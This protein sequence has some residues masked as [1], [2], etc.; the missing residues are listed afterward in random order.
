MHLLFQR[1]TYTVR[2]LHPLPLIMMMTIMNNSRCNGIWAH[3]VCNAGVSCQHF[4]IYELFLDKDKCECKTIWRGS[5]QQC[6]LTDS[7]NNNGSRGVGVSVLK[8]PLKYTLTI[9]GCVVL[10]F[11]LLSISKKILIYNGKHYVLESLVTFLWILFTKL[12]TGKIKKKTSMLLIN[13]ISIIRI[14]YATNFLLEQCGLK[15]HI[16]FQWLLQPLSWN[17]LRIFLRT[18]RT[19]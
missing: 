10:V 16:F 6:T 5:S 12:L 13:K 18:T 8:S 15:K 14:P 17:L 9:N 7:D 2:Y 3:V 11:G 4:V 1:H 19:N